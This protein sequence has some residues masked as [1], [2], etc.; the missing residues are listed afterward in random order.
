MEEQELDKECRL[1]LA[2]SFYKAE[3]QQHPGRGLL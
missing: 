1:S 2:P 3:R